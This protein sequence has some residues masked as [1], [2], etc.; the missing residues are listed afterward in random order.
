MSD[1]G[2]PRLPL[3]PRQAALARSQLPAASSLL[4]V[5][6]CHPNRSQQGFCLVQ[7][8]LIFRFGNGIGYD[9]GSRLH[10]GFSSLHP[11]G[12][13]SN[14]GIEISSEIGIEDRATIYAAADRLELFDDFH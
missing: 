3:D 14:A 5:I 10:V 4:L 7:A 9:A 13:D 12:A 6:P 1:R 11:H 8:F 2:E